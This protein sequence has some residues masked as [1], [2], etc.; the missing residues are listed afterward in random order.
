MTDS[1][2][3]FNVKTVRHIC[4]CINKG[5][6]IMLMDRDEKKECLHEQIF[7][8]ACTRY[9]YAINK[10]QKFHY[11][12]RFISIFILSMPQ[13]HITRLMEGE[14]LSSERSKRLLF[15]IMSIKLKVSFILSTIMMAH[16]HNIMKLSLFLVTT[17]LKLRLC[18]N[19]QQ[20]FPFE[21]FLSSS[22]SVR[23]FSMMSCNRCT[24][25]K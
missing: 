20:K 18:R 1:N 15:S 6:L 3:L 16:R 5:M 10:W 7:P 12:D 24:F 8:D 22:T 21:M 13:Q 19:K 2:N 17:C 4:V 23:V 14:K 9:I 25:F 11:D